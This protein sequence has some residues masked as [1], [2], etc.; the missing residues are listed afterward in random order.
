MSKDQIPDKLEIGAY[1]TTRPGWLCTDLT[2]GAAGVVALDATKRFPF[3]DNTFR[4]IYTEHTI[5]HMPLPAGQF[6]LGECHRVLRP[7]GVLRVVTPSIQFLIDL[8]QRKHDDYTSWSSRMFRP[9]DPPFPS[10]VFNCF[11]REWGH[12]FIYD[13][14]TLLWCMYKAGFDPDSF[15]HCALQE[16]QHPELCNLAFENRMPAGYLALESMIIE[17]T[18]PVVPTA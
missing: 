4:F 2:P 3:D 14:Q 1:A 16:S 7:G 6:M 9:N 10:V 15:I 12:Q 5:E 11:V 17:A 13:E 8:M 18:K